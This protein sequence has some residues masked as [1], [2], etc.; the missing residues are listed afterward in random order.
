MRKRSFVGDQRR[1]LLLPCHSWPDRPFERYTGPWT[2]D[3]GLRQTHHPVLFVGNAFDPSVRLLPSSLSSACLPT[4]LTLHRVTPFASAERM[5]TGFGSSGA[6]LKHG[7]HGHCSSAE[8]SVRS[9]CRSASR[10]LLADFYSSSPAL[11]GQGDSSLL[12]P[13]HSARARVLL[14]RRAGLHLCRAQQLRLADERDGCGGQGAAR[15][16]GRAG[17]RDR[18]GLRREAKVATVFASKDVSAADRM[19]KVPSG[20]PLSRPCSPR[21]LQSLAC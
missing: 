16:Y 21:P 7:G 17:Q 5:A 2:V 12:D 20:R 13:R 11:H 8:P 10:A 3:T 4:H 18:D 1:A 19:E 15:G 6:L 14:R 9:V